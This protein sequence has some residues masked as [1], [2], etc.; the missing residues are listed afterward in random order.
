[1]RFAAVAI[2]GVERG[3]GPRA[4]LPKTGGR[5]GGGPRLPIAFRDLLGDLALELG[6]SA[7]R[8][9]LQEHG[10]RDHRDGDG[11]GDDPPP[12]P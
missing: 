11:D 3:E 6:P 7:L 1:M 12:P 2:H 4:Q 10:E 5:G 9:L 8:G